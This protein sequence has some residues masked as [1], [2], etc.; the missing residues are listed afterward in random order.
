MIG[1]YRQDNKM[2]KL[3]INDTHLEANDL[4][5]SHVEHVI[6]YHLAD[7]ANAN[8]ITSFLSYSF[9]NNFVIPKYTIWHFR[10]V[11]VS[12]KRIKQLSQ[13]YS[14]FDFDFGHV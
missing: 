2:C 13:M 6:P 11:H 1:L 4:D 12:S 3:Q 7:Q 8:H 5:R 9:S 14:S 10:L